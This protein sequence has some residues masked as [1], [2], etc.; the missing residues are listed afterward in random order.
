MHES[1]HKGPV[2]PRRLLHK[3]LLGLVAGAISYALLFWSHGPWQEIVAAALVG[4]VV[5][6]VD[7]CPRRI[8]VGSAA[9]VTG[10]LVGTLLFGLWIELGIGAWLGAGAFLAGALAFYRRRWLILPGMLLGV[11]AGSVAESSRFLTVLATPLRNFD[12]QLLLLL[13]AGLFL[14]LV[15][16]L[17]APPLRRTNVL[18]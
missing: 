18:S 7:R 14:N 6:V 12:M 16:G 1:S 13:S 2:T 4:S 10:W 9:C 11:L 15:A 8:L 5:G 3:L 17:L